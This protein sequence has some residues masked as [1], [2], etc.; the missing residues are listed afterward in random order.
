MNSKIPV[1]PVPM[2]RTANNIDEALAEIKAHLYPYDE[3]TV[4]SLVML[5]HNT[6]IKE[7]WEAARNAKRDCTMGIGKGSANLFIHGDYDSI[8]AAQ[9]SITRIV[10]VPAG[11]TVNCEDTRY[12]ETSEVMKLLLDNGIYAK[13]INPED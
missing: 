4:H 6:L 9:Q 11:R 8:K 5:Y 10:Y 7:M 2:F 13:L 12:L 1:A 3:N